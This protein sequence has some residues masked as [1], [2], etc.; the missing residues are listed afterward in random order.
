MKMTGAQCLVAA[1]EDVGVQTVF[2]YPG[3]QAIDIYDALYDSQ[4]LHHVLVRHE[5][6]ATHAADGYARAT[7]KAG[8]VIVTSGPGATNTVT[9]IATAYM[10]SVP[11]VVIT[12]QVP[13]NVL[14]TDAF[15]ESDITGITL[16]IVKHSYLLKDPADI[17]PTVAAAYHIAQT[18]RP[19]PVLIDVP[20]NLAL[21][22]DVTYEFPDKVALDSYNPT[23]GGHARQIKQ[24][25]RLIEQAKRPVIYAGGGVLA[26][27]ACAELRAVATALQA[28]VAITLTAKGVFPE[29]DPLC[30][31]LAGMHGSRAANMALHES[32]LILAIGAR[33]ADRVTGDID[34]FA[35]N[36]KVVHIDID[37]AEISKNRY[38]DVPIVGDAKTVLNRFIDGLERAGVQP[39]TSEWLAQIE[40]WRGESPFYYEQRGDAISPEHVIELLD[41]KTKDR[42]TIYVTDVG[43]HQMWAA[44]YL[45]TT[46]SRTFLSSGGAG[47]MGFGLPAAMGAQFAKPESR[48]VCVTGDGSFQM[49]VQEMATIAENEL[50]I[51]VL[52][53]NNECLG[54]VRQLQE[55]FYDARYSNTVFKKNPDFKML[56]EAYGW[57][58]QRVQNPDDLEAML[59]AWLASDGP[60]LLEVLIPEM[61]NVYPM[62]P[63]GGALAD[64]F[65]YVTLDADGTVVDIKEKE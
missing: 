4:K 21:A 27:H 61:D 35:P 8:T 19:G 15:Q 33:F 23:I 34:A 12:G 54:M 36:A 32:D 7:G 42:D 17:A 25:L 46:R 48:V 60:C 65:G 13:T 40:T 55:L 56:A 22:K 53:L 57:S 51:K 44:Q 18:G 3:G 10:D 1:L 50:P 11:L 6:G 30:L 41:A 2:G 45:K 49:N 14:G 47:T 20:S 9:G 38:A 31:G 37:P 39:K 64:M 24:A 62:V 43:Q 29:T 59:D 28:P 5:Q 63:A 26:S 58:A 16:P 52:L